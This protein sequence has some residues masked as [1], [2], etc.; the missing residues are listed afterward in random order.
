MKSK[1]IFDFAL[2]SSAALFALLG[3]GC[4]SL[5]NSDSEKSLVPDT[6]GT[7]PNYWCSW[8][9]QNATLDGVG[10]AADKLKFAGDQGAA[11]ARENIGDSQIF[12]QGGWI[13]DFAPIRKDMYFVF[14]DGWDVRPGINPA[15][16]GYLFGS[17][18]VDEAK[19]PSCADKSPA[20]RL[21]KL[22]EKVKAR[23]WRGAG[24]WV[25][26]QCARKSGGE[27]VTAQAEREYWKQRVLWSKYAG[28]E[29][30]K[31]D[32]GTHGSDVAFRKMFTDLGREYYPDLI[33]EHTM[34]RG[35]VNALYFN[36]ERGKFEG[37][38]NM[39]NDGENL[40]GG[41][42]GVLAFSDTVRIYDTISPIGVASAFDRTAWHLVEGE[43]SGGGGIVNAEDDL[44]FG[45]AL[46]C[47]LG[48]MRTARA[49]PSLSD[50]IETRRLR[51][52]EVVRAVRWQRIAPA[53]GLD[54]SK[55]LISENRL[56]DDWTFRDGET[57]WKEAWGRNLRQNAP[58]AIVRNLPLPQ[59]SSAE[60]DLPFVAASMHPNGSIAIA[61][62]PRL[63]VGRGLYCPKAQV[64][65][66]TPD[67]TGRKIGIFGDFDSL[68]VN[69]GKKPARVLA[70]DLASDTPRDISA[71]CSYSDGKLTVFGKT[72]QSL[73]KPTT[74]SDKSAP[75]IVLSV[76]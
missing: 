11:S 14:D 35:P 10:K 58:A 71:E 72:A 63:K 5:W 31:V 40:L 25:A 29:Y 7:S 42:R 61:F 50:E 70:Q 8:L 75:A 54:K 33:I 62:V 66:D 76:E 43:K 36:S 65:L 37:R 18:E 26:A 20:E 67:A 69:V 15:T 68:T 34:P 9:T 60:G 53:F 28:V 17:L 48:V 24:I 47:S 56:E 12:A 59:V 57:W 55:T 19:F 73:C 64:R 1:R 2:G 51:M 46:G 16:E 23:G 32:W 6:A 38:G 30:W 13:D 22:N 41:V 3:L 27:T 49:K 45:A 39:F 74:P 4:S 52:T 21:K 44:Y